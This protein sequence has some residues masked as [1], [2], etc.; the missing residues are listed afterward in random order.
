MKLRRRFTRCL[1][2]F[3][4]PSVM[5]P[6]WLAANLMRDPEWTRDPSHATAKVCSDAVGKVL[7]DALQTA[8]GEM[9][10]DQA[11]MSVEAAK[12]LCRERGVDPE[13]VD[14][15]PREDP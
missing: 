15:L 13:L 14:R 4:G 12:R 10:P 6:P 7:C 5:A 11:W 8:F 3:A 1:G 2:L 9:A